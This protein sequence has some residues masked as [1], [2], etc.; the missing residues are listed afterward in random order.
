V[1]VVFFYPFYF[2]N[3]LV[4][5]PGTSTPSIA[6]LSC[7]AKFFRHGDSD[8]AISPKHSITCIATTCNFA[9]LFRV[10]Q[11]R[12]PR[13]IMTGKDAQAV[14][15]CERLGKIL[16]VKLD[17]TLRLLLATLQRQQSVMGASVGAS[18][19]A[20]GTNDV[21]II[22][23]LLDQRLEREEEVLGLLREEAELLCQVQRVVDDFSKIT[24]V[25]EVS[26]SQALLEEY[27]AA[28]MVILMD[29][30]SLPIV[31]ILRRPLTEGIA[32]I[33]N[34]EKNANSDRQSSAEAS[35]RKLQIRQSAERK[36]VAAAA[37]TLKVCL[38]M[39]HKGSKTKPTSPL[40]V[41]ITTDKLNALVLACCS[42]LPTGREI[43]E[44][45]KICFFEG[46]IDS[47]DYCIESV[48]ETI[49]CLLRLRSFSDGGASTTTKT[50]ELELASAMEGALLA[51]LADSCISL[52][53][54]PS[55]FPVTTILQAL[56]TFELLL[57]TSPSPLAWRS[58]FP[59]CF[60]VSMML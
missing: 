10:L 7:F 8:S 38:E 13:S 56:Q 60:A 43:A 15:K 37:S 3:T 4:Q 27:M 23:C 11:G 26:S 1:C 28:S 51:H 25:E 33:I 29:Y 21:F 6:T 55:S 35:R 32:A 12:A 14:G 5:V 52:V 19:E 58:L 24:L 59:G 44:L 49:S 18:G 41:C 9:K 47:G 30:I 50:D 34:A 31:A 48:L 36:S 40:P 53:A 54:P 20:E 22:G 2:C 46:G 42:A 17:P 16:F 39:I 45:S 57:R